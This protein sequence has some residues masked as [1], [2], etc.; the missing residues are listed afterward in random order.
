MPPLRVLSR[1]D[2][3]AGL[4]ALEALDRS[5]TLDQYQPYH[6][7]RA[8]MLRRA[9]DAEAAHDTYR[10]AWR[11]TSNEIERKFLKNRM[12]ETLSDR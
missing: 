7:A 2:R 4:A 5:E 3:L 1:M 9:G 11:L 10:T 8:D 12:L 6:V